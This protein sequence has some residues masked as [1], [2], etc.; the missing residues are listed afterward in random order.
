MAGVLV[1]A[2]CDDNPLDFDATQTD[3]L[4]VNPTSMVLPGGRTQKLD[5]RAVNKGMEPTY[6]PVSFSAIS[7]GNGLG[8]IDVDADED[9]LPIQPPGKLVVTAGSALG[10]ACVALEGGG[11]RDTVDVVVVADALTLTGPDTVIAGASGTVVPQIVD[12]DGNPMTP[13]DIADA[14][15]ES[16]DTDIVDVDPATGD[17]TTEASGDATV[18]GLWLGTE[19]TGTTDQGVRR[20]ASHKITVLPSTIVDIINPA[21]VAGAGGTQQVVGIDLVDEFG[22]V[23][24][25]LGA[26]SAITLTTTPDP[27]I[28]TAVAEIADVL[29]PVTLEVIGEKPTVTVGLVAPGETTIA[30][31]ITTAAGGSYDFDFTVYVV[32]PVLSAITLDNGVS[33]DIVVLT[34]SGF[35]QVGP[36]T[37]AVLVNGQELAGNVT[38]DSDNQITVQMPTQSLAVEGCTVCFAPS[39]GEAPFAISVSI[40]GVETESLAWTLN[41]ELDVLATEP[42]NDSELTPVQ[43]GVPGVVNGAFE[44]ADV[45]DFFRITISRTS[46]ISIF[47]DWNDHDVDLD[48]L[49]DDDGLPFNFPCGFPGATGNAPER[50][51]C[52]DVPPGSY[53]IWIN[54]YSGPDNPTPYQFTVRVTEQG[55]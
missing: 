33:G 49:F 10:E 8:E 4:E 55:G 20:T 29:D 50:H 5:V 44:G 13:F 1:A 30:G 6:A 42:A 22:N 35:A 9:Q 17:F 51:V 24:E 41:E 31:T 19:A 7:C 18:S 2:S 45:D 23:N 47:L 26:Y 21:D 48:I 46:T 16:S 34:G 3:R 43:I 39:W 25:L 32:A 54:N 15:L 28:A 36:F 37:S 40:A 12:F 52:T 14:N 27:L 53:L 38:V 11:A